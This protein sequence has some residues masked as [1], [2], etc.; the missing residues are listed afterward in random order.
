MPSQTKMV[1]EIPQVGSVSHPCADSPA[2][3]VVGGSAAGFLAASLLARGGRSVRVFERIETL[4]PAPRT[5]IVTHR[6]RGLLGR[7]GERSVVNEIRRFELFTD[8]RSAIIALNQPDLII[9]RR[10]LIQA[11]AKD[12][13]EAGAAVE[14]G[15]SFQALHP[16]RNG[17]VVEIERGGNREQIH[18]GTVI[19]ADGAGSRV[20][21]AAGWPALG[22]L[23]L[24]QAIVPLPKDM[25]PD[26]ARIWFIPHETPYFYWLIPESATRGALGLIGEQGPRTARYLEKFLEKRGLEPIEFQAA[27]VPVYSPRVSFQRKVGGGDVYLVGDA[28]GQVK[29]TTVG[30]IVTGF[31]GAI[32]V[33][34]AI[35]NGASSELRR[36]HRELNSHLL[37]RRSLHHFQQPDYSRLID[38]LNDRAKQSLGEYSRDEAWKVLWHVCL[39]QPKLVLLGIRGLLMRGRASHCD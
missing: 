5:L 34:Q 10:A 15:C 19:G 18:A 39:R 25:S 12:A 26:S 23:P 8:G 38:L 33:A 20:A 2:I 9:E 4:E 29:V 6:M 13:R 3:A 28:A 27:R 14:L 22:T 37:L 36:L 1:F 30:G 31:R 17:V 35:L 24:V 16:N 21:R 11:L 32:G 7:A